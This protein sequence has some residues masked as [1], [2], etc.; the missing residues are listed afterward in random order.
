MKKIKFHTILSGMAAALCLPLLLGSCTD[1][2]EPEAVNEE[3]ILTNIVLNVTNPLS[4]LAG[5]DS[6]VSYTLFPENSTKKEIVW[7][8]ADETIATVD[9]EGRISA[10]KAGEVEI[11]VQ[12]VAGFVAS[13]I[14]NVKVVDEIIKMQSISIA[15]ETGETSIYATA[16][17][18]LTA[19][20]L[21]EN[22]T[23]PTWEWSSETPEIVSVTQEGSV[24]G[25]KEGTGIIK[26]SSTDGGNVS[27]TFEIEVKRIIPIE[28]VVVEDEEELFLGKGQHSKLPI[29]V[30]PAD[31]TM[32]ALEWSSA[33]PEIV[34]I[35]PDGM[36]TTKDYGTVTLTAQSGDF[37]KDI[38]V[39]VVEGKINDVFAY[40]D[41]GWKYQ[42]KDQKFE[43]AWTEN[44]KLVVPLN[45]QFSPAYR[46]EIN[47]GKTDFHA[48]NYPILA[49]K[50]KMRGTPNLD[51]HK[52]DLNIW[53][54]T[55]SP[56][57]LGGERSGSMA[58]QTLADGS[59][60]YHGNLSESGPGFINGKN[61]LDG[62]PNGILTLDNM[63]FVLRDIN[64]SNDDI[65]SGNT[66]FDVEWVKT[67]RSEEAFNEFVNS[68]K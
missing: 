9:G 43:K 19:S 26:V 42:V 5:T 1:Y 49:V 65:A 67:F 48:G 66:Y 8:S 18:Q 17:V 13:S 7:K 11:T 45:G 25:L 50:I 15:S 47:R 30:V 35:T 38:E 27:A 14:L 54:G 56:G 52:C 33:N 31:A 53:G 68:G 51:K 60:V 36:L 29:T 24:T 37:K 32:T 55:L 63:I 58:R 64:M 23:Y 12:S 4:L 44:N 62:L 40:G 22:T 46:A 2:K 59:F 57:W 16:S 6:L 39:T 20:Y 3:I 21:P 61:R 34:E 41:F 10:L 28:D